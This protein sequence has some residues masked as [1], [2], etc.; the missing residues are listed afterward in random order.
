MKK[1]YFKSWDHFQDTEDKRRQHILR[2]WG[3]RDFPTNLSAYCSQGMSSEIWISVSVRH[4]F[5]QEHQCI[6]GEIGP[7]PL[8]YSDPNNLPTWQSSP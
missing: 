2:V 8:H 3:H 6:E 7:S 5:R 1:V 4:R